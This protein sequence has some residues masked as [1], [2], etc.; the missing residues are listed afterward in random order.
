MEGPMSLHEILTGEESLQLW[1]AVVNF[2]LLVL[3]LVWKG[4]KPVGDFLGGR[5]SEVETRMAE[6]AA[7][8]AKAE[9]AFKEYSDKLGTLDHELAKLR[10][11]ISRAAEEDKARILKEAQESAQRLVSETESLIVRQ[12]EQWAQSVRREV[13]EAALAAAEQ[14]LKQALTADDQSRLASEYASQLAQPR[15]EKRV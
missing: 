9:A 3:I 7:M 1:G 15:T 13:V 10:S 2:S 4:K 12:G 5:R 6:A 14:V 8:K 11:D